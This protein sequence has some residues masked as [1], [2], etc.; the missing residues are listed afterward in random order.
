MS[1]KCLGRNSNSGFA[2]IICFSYFYMCSASII[3]GRNIQNPIKDLVW[4]RFSKHNCRNFPWIVLFLPHGILKGPLIYCEY[5]STPI[6]FSYSIS[7]SCLL[8]KLTVLFA[9]QTK[10]LFKFDALSMVFYNKTLYSDFKLQ[11]LYPWIIATI[12][13]YN[14][15][16]INIVAWK[17]KY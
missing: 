9:I 5:I 3:I 10:K 4:F 8:L 16:L 12:V 13:L 14:K 7:I 15:P 6:Y 11:F 2:S 17:I 1:Q